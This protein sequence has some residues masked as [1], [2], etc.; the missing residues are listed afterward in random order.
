VVHRDR[1]FAGRTIG[2]RELIAAAVV[3]VLLVIAGLAVGGV[4][5]HGKQHGSPSTTPSVPTTTPSRVTTTAP[6]RPTGPPPVPVPTATLKTGSNGAQVKLLQRALAQLGY[7]PGA[8][9]GMFGPVTEAA[10]MRF[11]TAAKLAPDGV[12][13]PLTLAALAKALRSGG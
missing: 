12:V 1:L 11:Q 10:V 5:T 6:S 13:G 2:S 9:D 4:F 3:V 8:V 7:K